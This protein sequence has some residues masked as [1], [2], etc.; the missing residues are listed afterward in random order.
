MDKQQTQE[1]GQPATNAA[2]AAVAKAVPNT[3][4]ATLIRG[5]SYT[6]GNVMF[7]P[8]QRIAVPQYIKDHLEITAIDHVD[9][10]GEAEAKPKFAFEVIGEE[11][12]EI[13]RALSRGRRTPRGA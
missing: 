10:E 1:A 4:Y 3:H 7:K 12:A 11:G 6:L 9:V 8:G 5:E 13:P 2:A